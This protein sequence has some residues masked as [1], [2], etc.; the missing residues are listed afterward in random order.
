VSILQA[1]VS[2]IPK[3]L[4]S[5]DSQQCP[6]CNASLIAQNISPVRI[7]S[8]FDEALTLAWECPVCY[9]ADVLPGM[10]AKWADFVRDYGE[11]WEEIN[12]SKDH[13]REVYARVPAA[14]PYPGCYEAYKDDPECN[15]SHPRHKRGI[16]LRFTESEPMRVD[17]GWDGYD[18]SVVPYPVNP[19]D[20]EV[21]E[22]K[23]EMRPD[24]IF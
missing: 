13:E 8:R 1:P 14:E 6:H 10:E 12:A 24:V 3:S 9:K 15:D 19:E 2:Q 11:I 20:S 4:L 22:D 23:F 17:L 21:P 5:L 18:R 7:S 16:A